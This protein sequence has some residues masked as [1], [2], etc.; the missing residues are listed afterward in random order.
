MIYCANPAAQFRSYQTEIEAAIRRV[1][2]GNRYILGPEVEA[3]EQE[4]ASYIGTASAIGVANG[5]DA[6]ELSLRSLGLGRGDEVITVSHTAVATV[7]AIEA[8]GATPV[9]VDV[10]PDYYTLDPDQLEEVLTSRTRAVIAV[11]LYGQPADLDAIGAF[12]SKHRLALVEDVSQ[13]HGSCWRGKRLG[14]IGHIGCFSCYPTKNLGAVGDGG[15][16]TTNDPQIATSV[17]MLREY[18]WR[19]RYISEIPGRNSRLDELQAAILRVKLRHLDSDNAKRRSLAAHYDKL[20][21]TLPLQLPKTR[22]GAEHVYH[23]Y[24]VTTEHRAALVATLN[25]HNI[26]PGIHYPVPVHLQAAYAHRVNTALEM[27]VTE[28]LAKEVLS[29]PLY[30]EFPNEDLMRVAKGIEA[31]FGQS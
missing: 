3:L 30:P 9:L 7:A 25:Q 2:L 17:K 28:A 4:F 15:L 18:G 16:I 14:S 6:I 10:V 19:E 20:L 26:F 23:L 8:A 31:C 13:A 24:V 12:C 29:L 22:E 5:T 1:L 21:R 11:H 27:G